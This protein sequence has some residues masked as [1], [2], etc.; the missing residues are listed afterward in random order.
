MGAGGTGLAWL[1]PW[2]ESDASLREG[3]NRPGSA[4]HLPENLA[5]VLAPLWASVSPLVCGGV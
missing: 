4:T 3:E 2:A 5:Q 1:E